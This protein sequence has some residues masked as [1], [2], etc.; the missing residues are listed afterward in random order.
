[1]VTV[2]NA[3]EKYLKLQE[4]R[5]NWSEATKNVLDQYDGIL[6]ALQKEAIQNAWDAIAEDPKDW[7]IEIRCIPDEQKLE[8]EDF[9]TTG[10]VNWEYYK[11]LWYSEKMTQK[12]KG[13]SRGQGKFVLVA[14]GRYM[15]TETIVDGKYKVVYTNNDAKFDDDEERVVKIANRKLD[16]PGTLVTVYG[17]RPDFQKEFEDHKKMIKLIQLTWWKIIQDRGATIIYKVGTKEY[18]VRSLQKPHY[19]T[20][21]SFPDK[22]A[23]YKVKDKHG[24]VIEAKG[25]LTDINFYY[26]KGSD[27]PTEFRGKVAITVNGQTIE[28]WEP[29]SIPPPHNNRFFGTVEAEYLR[30]AEQPNHSKFKR[31]HD[32]WKVTKT[33][34]E[35]LVQEFLQP[36]YEKETAV[37]KQSLKEAMMAEELLNRAFLEGF[38]D[39]DP[40]G[41]IPKETRKREKY[42]DVYI[43]YLLL[44]HREY[45][46]G[47]TVVAKCVVANALDENRE[48]YTV[49]YAV[50]DPDGSKICEY[51][52]KELLFGPKEEIEFEFKC[53]L[54]K[55]VSKGTYV[56]GLFVKNAA[57]EI[58]HEIAKKFEVEPEPVKEEPKELELEE[59]KKDK[60]KEKKKVPIRVNLKLGVFKDGKLVRYFP[61]P[62]NIIYVN[63]KHETIEFIRKSVPKALVYHLVVI[64]GE[65][66]VR[67]RYKSLI[68]SAEESGETLSPEKM[69]QTI[70]ELVGRTQELGRWVGKKLMVTK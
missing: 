22:A 55:N 40:V 8:I 35:A 66:L 57:G 15:I 20:H 21:K 1:M 34:L 60:D 58:V 7:R 48:N 18:K 45:S 30:D 13:G 16:H 69:K 56:S 70:D 52:H 6:D 67:L 41:E 23:K 50:I 46:R 29:S 27:L 19:T 28:W 51:E 4:P 5:V 59:L 63:Y 43:R 44:D 53:E 62:V 68:D 47:D 54:P 24:Q 17:T 31:D 25:V 38:G 49:Q 42:N 9:G 12:G 61:A 26:N 65:E 3:H 33:A 14:A 64:S 37:D 36:M 39:I 10:I 2:E 11:S 32:A